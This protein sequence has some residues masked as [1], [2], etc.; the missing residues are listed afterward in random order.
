MHPAKLFRAKP[1][2]PGDGRV[3]EDDAAFHRANDEKVID[4]LEEILKVDLRPAGGLIAERPFPGVDD[5]PGDCLKAFLVLSR[6]YPLG[7]GIVETDVA[8]HD[9]V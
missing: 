8:A 7:V 4:G 2:F 6:P 1:E 9:S 5:Q 3:G